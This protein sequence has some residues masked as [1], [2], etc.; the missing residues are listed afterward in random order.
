MSSNIDYNVVLY[1]WIS[2]TSKKH[3]PEQLIDALGLSA[4]P[5]TQTKGAC[6]YL[7]RL[8]F[9]SI[10]IHFNGREDM[11][12][13]VEMTGQGCRNFEELTTLSSRYE[14]LFFFI[15]SNNLNI[16]RLD[17]AYDDHVGVLDIDTV[18]SDVENNN[19][20][21][22]MKYWEVVRSSKGTGV[23]IGSPQ[24]KVRVRIYD[25][26]AERGFS[27]GSHWVRV[28]LQLRD[29]RAAEFSM[30]PMPVGE[31]F[32]GVLLNYLRFVSPDGTDSNKSRWLTAPYW[33]DFIGDVG[34]I[35]IFTEPGSDYNVAR[36][37]HYVFDMAGNA[38]DAMF[39]ICGNVSDFMTLLSSRRCAP[40]P[41]YDRLV[42][43][44]YAR[45]EAW[46]AKV[47]RYI[48][49]EDSPDPVDPSYKFSPYS[50]V[51]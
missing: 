48:D 33:D 47:R 3:T 8:Y 25:K 10:S 34:R 42:D 49:I 11:G 26:A 23:Y 31:A 38:I 46:A 18:A 22:R 30:I 15:H 36:C 32:A 17:V 14:D 9:G 45:Q 35:R 27:D 43:E 12:V 44:H 19:F 6:G 4:C 29:G 1:D 13:W 16:T 20:I 2:F 51:V 50:G 5:W 21:S 39:R 7:D 40:N 41:K 24:S 28:E 37:K